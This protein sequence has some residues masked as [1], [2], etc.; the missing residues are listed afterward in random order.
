MRSRTIGILVGG[1]LLATACGSSTHFANKPRPPVPVNLTVYINNARVSVSHSSVGAG[2]VVF[3]ITN[4]AQQA[5]SLTIAPM[6]S[7]STVATTGPINPQ[8][9]TQVTVNLDSPGEYELTTGTASGS[10]HPAP[11]HIG[12]ARPSAASQ[13]LQP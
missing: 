12:P 9:T 4:Q 11:L 7:G 6:H 13:L 3:I 5:E 1:A 10:I 8:G 2:P